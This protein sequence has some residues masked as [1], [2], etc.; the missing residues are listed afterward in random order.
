MSLVLVGCASNKGPAPLRNLSSLPEDKQAIKQGYYQVKKGD[1]LYAIAFKLGFD[2]KRLARING[3]KAPYQIYA[4]QRL[5]LSGSVAAK[6]QG[7]KKA[8]VVTNQP[9]TQKPTSKT[10]QSNSTQK[11]APTPKI[12]QDSSAIYDSNRSVKD[13][14]WPVDKQIK[15]QFSSKKDGLK[16]IALGGKVGQSIKSAAA[17]RVVYTGNGLVGYGNLIIIKH[18]EHLLSAYAHTASIKVKEQQLVR[19]GQ[20]I[21]TMGKN[22]VGQVQLHFEIRNQGRPVNPL[23]YLP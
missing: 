13:W 4:G 10:V 23:K 22:D 6:Q 16:G 5:K 8:K 14:Q 20:V 7:S 17:G 15:K 3:I 11:P 12:A 18:S 21:A 1:T 19:A 9:K 2:F